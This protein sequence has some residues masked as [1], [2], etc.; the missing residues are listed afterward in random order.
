M[1][2]DR[3]TLGLNKQ[4]FCRWVSSSGLPRRKY[5]ECGSGPHQSDRI[6]GDAV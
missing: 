2:D 1:D 5:A 4:P 6:W 3:A